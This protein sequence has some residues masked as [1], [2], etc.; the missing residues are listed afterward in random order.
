MMAV[1]LTPYNEYLLKELETLYRLLGRPVTATLLSQHIDRNYTELSKRLRVLQ[2]AGYLARFQG[3]RR[4]YTPCCNNPE[5][6]KLT[7]EDYVLQQISRL[8]RQQGHGI[9]GARLAAH[10]GTS[11]T[12]VY[13]HLRRLEAK[14]LIARPDGQYGGYIVADRTVQS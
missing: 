11:E 12:W 6:S 3:R 10:I 1:E 9:S 8:S 5:L 2:A 14:G 13:Q 4:G 7:A